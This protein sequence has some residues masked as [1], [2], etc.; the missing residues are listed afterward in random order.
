MCSFWQCWRVSSWC[1]YYLMIRPHCI[2]LWSSFLH[3]TRIGRK[4]KD[5]ALQKHRC[6]VDIGKGLVLI[7][8]VN[9]FPLPS[10]LRKTLIVFEICAKEF[11]MSTFACHSFS[12]RIFGVVKILQFWNRPCITVHVNLFTLLV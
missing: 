3:G 9:A 5:T 10:F 2:F 12:Y 1:C 6:F 7:S 11:R 4:T 8:T